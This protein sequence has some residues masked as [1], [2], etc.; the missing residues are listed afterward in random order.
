M[1]N[2]IR[3][4]ILFPEHLVAQDFQVRL[5]VVIDG[6]EN[7]AVLGE[8]FPRKLQ[9]RQHHAEPPAVIGAAA[10]RVCHQRNAFLVHL[11]C[12]FQVVVHRFPVIVGID[13][14][15]ARV[16]WRIDVDHLDAF[17]IALAQNPQHFQVVAFDI[18][19]V[20]PD[21]IYAVAGN[22]FERPFRRL[23]GELLR[24]PLSRPIQVVAHLAF[25]DSLFAKQFLQRA[26]VQLAVPNEFRV[27]PLERFKTLVPE[28][29]RVHKRI[30]FHGHRLPLVFI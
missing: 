18:D 2:H 1:P 22:R 10:L 16:V 11:P 20:C 27:K 25:I 23:A 29:G 14:V 8:Q 13:K 15:L 4:K 19:V 30:T 5:L 17:R 26:N 21:L 24:L 28:R 9:A 7:H 6:D 3:H 12:K